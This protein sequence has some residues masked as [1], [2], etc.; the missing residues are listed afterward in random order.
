M[1]RRSFLTAATAALPACGLPR[2]AVKF[3]AKT[4]GGERISEETVKGK[5]VLIQFWTT[6][7]GYCRREQP[8]VDELYERFRG[9]LVVLAVN[10]GESKAK[11]ENYLSGKPRRVPVVLQPDT[12]LAALF[13]ARGFPK[14]VVLNRQG[15][16][17]GQQDGAGGEDA[18]LELLD[19]AGLKT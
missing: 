3:R 8:M 12:N 15:V 10:A 9:E 14:Y 13:P 16:A 5:V 1:D 6:W 4:L 11:V 2:D 7:C 19:R 18:L 17:T